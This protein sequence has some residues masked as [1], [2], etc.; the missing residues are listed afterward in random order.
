[1]VTMGIDPSINCTGICIYD[2]TNNTNEYYMITG[3]A[4]KKML[5]FSNDHVTIMPYTKRSYTNDEYPVKERKKTHNINDICN[6][7]KELICR[8][9]PDHVNMEG[10]SYGSRGSAAL[11]DLAGLNHCIRMTLIECDVDYDIIAPAGVKKFAVGNGSVEKDVIIA[12]WKKLDRNISDISDIKL[13]D[14]ADSYF[15]AHYQ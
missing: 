1:M 9:K 6:I 10:I 13:D 12:S 3:G 5:Q 14:L 2:A 7:I 15:I 11:A 8:H 4:T